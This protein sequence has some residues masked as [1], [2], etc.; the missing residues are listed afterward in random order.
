MALQYC[1][2]PRDDLSDNPPIARDRLFG[3]SAWPIG[4]D[5]PSP[6]SER[7]PLGEHACVEVQYPPTHKRDIQRCLR[8]TT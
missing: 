7:F 6:F 2:V 5:T 8:D 4:C 3:A 1:A